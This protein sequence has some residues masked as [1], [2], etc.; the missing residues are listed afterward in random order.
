MDAHPKGENVKRLPRRTFL[1]LAASAALI[2]VGRAAWAQ[3]YPSR[4]VRIIVGFA[5]GGSVDVIA[6]LIGQRLSRQLGQPVVV[7]NRPGAS[8]NIGTELV[9]GAPADGYTLLLATSSNAINATLYGKLKF[10]FIRDVTAV[11]SISRN[12]LVMVANPSVPV[13]NVAAFIAHAK[14]NPGK[15][16]FASAGNGTPHHLSGELFKMMTGVDIL[17]VPYRGEAP[18]LAD[19]IGGQVDV[20]FTTTAPSIGYIRSGDLRALAV[21][22]SAPLEA[23]PGIPTVAQSVPGFE[24][25]GWFGVGAPKGTP[26]EIV[27]RLNKEINADLADPEFR[28]RFADLGLSVSASSSAD[29]GKFVA[30]DTQKWA[31]VIRAANIEPE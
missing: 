7:E 27:E 13:T 31:K 28:A 11:A 23:L 6:R 26:S 20:M 4:P 22:T 15:V 29:F 16:T 19:L 21:T 17:H 30:A 8:S 3:P 18:A 12:P 2:G 10:N 25:S 14:A 5:P 1:H 24:A 9:V